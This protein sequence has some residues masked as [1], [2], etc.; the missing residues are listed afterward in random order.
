MH[1][2]RCYQIIMITQRVYVILVRSPHAS[3][4]PARRI[5][6][7]GT[8]T[9]SA[10]Q[11]FCSASLSSREVKC[12]FAL[13]CAFLMEC[14]DNNEQSHP[15]K[16]I[17]VLYTEVREGEEAAAGWKYVRMA[18]VG[19]ILCVLGQKAHVVNQRVEDPL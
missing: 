15:H 4:G 5:L 10:A 16:R 2:Q 9:R 12:V 6:M 18:R 19:Q 3:Q 11:Q 14:V 7:N 1:P 13:L 17:I 8:A